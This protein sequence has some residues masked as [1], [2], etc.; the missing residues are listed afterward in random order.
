MGKTSRTWAALPWCLAAVTAA[1]AGLPAAARTEGGSGGAWQPLAPWHCSQPVMCLT[2]SPDGKLLAT[3]GG[4]VRLT[5]QPLPGE[6][7]LWDVARKKL[8]YALKGHKSYVLAVAFS[9]DGKQLLSVSYDGVVKRWNVANGK[10]LSSR[11]LGRSLLAL[12]AFS[13]SRKTLA[14]H[15]AQIGNRP[16]GPGAS[17]HLWDL[18]TGRRQVTFKAHDVFVNKMVFAP[19]GKRLFTGGTTADRNAKPKPGESYSGSLR[20]EMKVWDLTARKPKGRRLRGEDPL[21]GMTPD[22]KTLVSY[23]YDRTGKQTSLRFKDLAANKDRT[24]PGHA[25]MIYDIAFS[26][27]GKTLATASWDK[28]VKV[29]DASTLKEVATLRGHTQVVTVVALTPD[30]DVLASGGPDR[31]VRLWVRKKK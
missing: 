12:V 21:L 4:G 22:G 5:G 25:G 16:Q 18:T 29:W 13:P 3:G 10:L 8:R 20:G 19:N 1:F 30:G 15:F 2:F 17:L 11:R 6:L 31:T 28:T 7:K 9:P 26:K 24:V 23:G 14:V 27:D